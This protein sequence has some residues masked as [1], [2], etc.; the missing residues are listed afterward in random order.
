MSG[1][2]RDFA[3]H[4]LDLPTITSKAN[5]TTRL[6]DVDELQSSGAHSLYRPIPNPLRVPLAL[7]ASRTGHAFAS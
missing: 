6:F 4:I 1:A 3:R 7:A 2:G 5:L